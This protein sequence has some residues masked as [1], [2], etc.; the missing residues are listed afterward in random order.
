MSRLPRGRFNSSMKRQ[1]NASTSPS[2][3]ASRGRNNGTTQSRYIR[4]SRKR[5][6]L[7]S[8]RRAL[9]VAAKIRTKLGREG[10]AVDGAKRALDGDRATDNSGRLHVRPT[11]A[12]P[13]RAGPTRVQFSSSRDGLLW[14][15]IL[16]SGPRSWVDVNRGLGHACKHDLQPVRLLES[17]STM[18]SSR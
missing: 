17:N 5:P 1:N 4:S 15:V 6:S 8:R 7:T 18:P 10:R 9:F 2:R 13:P 16:G 11:I 12:T 3:S 14:L